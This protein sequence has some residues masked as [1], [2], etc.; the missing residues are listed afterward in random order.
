VG[1]IRAGLLG[2][3]DMALRASMAKFKMAAGNK[4]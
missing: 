3:S 1:D 2:H 4:D